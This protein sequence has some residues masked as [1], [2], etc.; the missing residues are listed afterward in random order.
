MSPLQITLGIISILVG[1]PAW[2]GF[3]LAVRNIVRTIRLGQPAPD[4]FGP[5]LPRIATLVKEFAAH[6]RMVKFRTVGWAHWLVMVGFLLGFVTVFQAQGQIFSPTF[7]WPLIGDTLVYHLLDELLGLGTIVGVLALIIIR[8]A[9]HPRRPAR[10]SRFSGSNFLAAYFVEL[11][12][13]AEGISMVGVKALVQA[14]TGEHHAASDFVSMHIAKLLPASAAAVSVFA[15]CKLMTAL[16]WVV[17]VSRNIDWG[18]AWH[19]FAAFFNIYF[20]REA[21]GGVALGAAKPMMSGGKPIE[22]ET[23]DPDNDTFGVGRFE[24]FS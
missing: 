22:M 1:V 24:D 14:Y 17:V 23:A 20:K 12:V 21:D 8:Q 7:T 11:I 16:V 15:F 4:R 2:A 18:V 19:R 13:L 10:L 3:V 9:N 6:T 5:F